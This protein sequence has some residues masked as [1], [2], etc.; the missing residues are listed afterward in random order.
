MKSLI[1]LGLASLLV[2]LCAVHRCQSYAITD[3][4]NAQALTYYDHDEMT[5]FLKY[6]SERY[7]DFT[8][9]YTI[10]KSVEGRDLWVLLVTRDPDNE[11]LLKPNV[12]YV[13]NIHGDETVGRQ[14]MVYLI[15][16]LLIQYNVDPHVR[17]LVDNTRI[18]IMPSMNPDGFAVAK[19]GICDG[20]TGRENARGVDLNRNFPNRYHTQT[21][22]E[23]P[24]TTAVR[25]WSHNI[26]FVLAASLHGGVLVASYPYDHA[27]SCLDGKYE[28]GP[29]ASLTSDDDV[30]R[31]LARVYSFNHARMHLG[32]TCTY[33]GVGFQNGTTNG[34]AWYAFQGSMADFNY[35]HEGCLDV[36]LE[37]SCCKFP[38]SSELPRMW[39]ENKR[40]LLAYLGEVHKGVRGI[41]MDDKGL[42]V[43][44]A[45]VRTTDRKS[46]FMTSSRGEYWKIL[47]PGSYTLVVTAPGFQDTTHNFSVYEGEMTIVNV[48]LKT[49]PKEDECLR[50]ILNEKDRKATVG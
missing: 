1:L 45:S 38:H 35:I 26:P 21:D 48:T 5:A 40:P 31:H 25:A 37:V 8:K 29:K 44:R 10:G 22:E 49:L 4:G 46:K 28:T 39:E 12:K 24:E 41:I 6:T 33:N 42:P 13:A 18:H 36:T 20:V 17:H 19:E 50:Q 9:L 15:S 43:A 27:A 23:Q 47:R 14:L 3:V 16:H 34:A 2:C 30:F 32:E 7:P 11:V